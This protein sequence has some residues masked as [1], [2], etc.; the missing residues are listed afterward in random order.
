MDDKDTSSLATM[1]E[2]AT[3]AIDDAAISPVVPTQA[4]KRRSWP[5][6]QTRKCSLKTPL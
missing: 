2:T 6:S 5:S 1:A 4:P 3:S